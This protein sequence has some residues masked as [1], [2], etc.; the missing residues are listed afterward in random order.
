MTQAW[1]FPA[2]A[3]Y[4]AGSCP[5]RLLLLAPANKVYNLTRAYSR[6]GNMPEEEV[7]TVDSAAEPGEHGLYP[8]RWVVLAA[9]M[10][11]AA[12]TQLMWLTYAPITSK[13]EG[14]LGWSEFAIVLLATMYPLL[15]IPVSIPAGIVIDSKD[16]RYA[17]MIGAV[18]TA[19]CSF[20]RLFVDNYALVLLGSIGIALGQPFVLNSI[21]KMVS[22]W[23]PSRES[24]L[25]TGL[26]T[27]ALFLGMIVVQ[28]LSPLLLEAFGEDQV[29]SLRWI[30]LIYSIAAVA[31][32][33]LFALLAKPRPPRPPE[34][35]EREILGA[36]AAI[37]WKSMGTIF[38][39]HDFRLLCVIIFIGNGAFVG[40]LQLLE[41]ILQPKGITSTT[42]GNIGA[43]MVVAGVAGCVVIPAI[44]DKLMRRKPFLII[45]AAVA[46]PAIFLIGALE[47]TVLIFATGLLLGF[48]LFAA[49]PLVLTLCEETTGAALTGTATSILLLLGN[50]G[51]VFITLAMEGIKGATGGDSGSF[52][53]ALVFLCALFAAALVTGFYLQEDSGA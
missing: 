4:V 5:Q 10:L 33:L 20:L 50:A 27:V 3:L 44:S 31:G 43:V 16:W 12:F 45:A 6:G 25:A 34:R 1:H 38:S 11:I 7:T 17:V 13:M 21:T 52:F 47:S 18:L 30:I 24:A 40:L 8:Y 14:M 22:A 35:D 51:G 2:T 32:L 29:S 41:K 37:N 46:I 39:L 36:D 26:A 15:Y 28:V 19:G 42:A 49:Y 48:F 9:F 53:W 23:F